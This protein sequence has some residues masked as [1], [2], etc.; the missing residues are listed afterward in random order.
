MIFLIFFVDGFWLRHFAQ[1]N[2]GC[3][4]VT[5]TSEYAIR[6]ELSH[7]DGVSWELVVP[8]CDDTENS[9]RKCGNEMHPASIYYPGSSTG[10]NR[11]VIPMRKIPAIGPSVRFRWR[12]DPDALV[13]WAINDV[14]IGPGCDQMCNGHGI[15]D[16]GA[17]LCDP[18]YS[19]TT[20]CDVTNNL[21]HLLE[22]FDQGLR[23]RLPV[24]LE[25]STVSKAFSQ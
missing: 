25:Q 17:C 24:W 8:H 15:C 16:H 13:K 12:Q 10:W 23:G 7:D 14:Y 21:D 3:G 5:P 4:D 11:I 1:I 20:C 18:G 2:I 6:F 22:T 9:Q 19:G